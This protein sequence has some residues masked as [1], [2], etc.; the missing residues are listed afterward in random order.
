MLKGRELKVVANNGGLFA[1]LQWRHGRL[2]AEQGVDVS[3]L[4]TLSQK[5]NFTWELSIVIVYMFI[6]IIVI[7]LKRK[8]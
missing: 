4:R 7:E 8:N 5:L 3:I 2:V 1:L 6:K